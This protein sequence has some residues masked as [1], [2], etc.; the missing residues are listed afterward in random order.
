M[1]EPRWITFSLD[2]K[3]IAAVT[4]KGSFP[5]EIQDTKELLACEKGVDPSEIVVGTR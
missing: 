3:E 4:I 1:N 2:G 5:G